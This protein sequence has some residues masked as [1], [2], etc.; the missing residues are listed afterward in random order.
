MSEIN[1]KKTSLCI[2]SM[3]G[4]TGKTTLALN[5]AEYFA[6]KVER[7]LIIDLDP[8]SH[9]CLYFTSEESLLERSQI[10]LLDILKF[11]ISNVINI[12]EKDEEAIGLLRNLFLRSLIHRDNLSVVASSPDISEIESQIIVSSTTSAYSVG[13]TPT[14]F[15]IPVLI[16]L[17]YETYDMVIIDCPPTITLEMVRSAYIGSRNVLI[18]TDPTRF[19]YNGLEKA[20]HWYL[21]AKKLFNPHL[22]L[23][24]IVMTRY[25]GRKMVHRAV[26]EAIQENKDFAGA[27][28]KPPLPYLSDYEKSGHLN[29]YIVD[30]SPHEKAAK[31][32]LELMTNLER[33]LSYEDTQEV[34]WLRKE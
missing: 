24:G 4:G 13:N 30:Y 27:F 1:G 19:G 11:I 31:T 23:A 28:L 6:K 33:R 25:D 5:I 34:L 3:K 7:V 20:H 12:Y 2:T 16:Q 15:L 14:T 10:K 26:M 29:Q 21:K 8:Q 22:N 17:A 9:S 18:P 32:F